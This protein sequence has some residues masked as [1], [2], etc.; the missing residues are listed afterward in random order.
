MPTNVMRCPVCGYINTGDIY[1]HHCPICKSPVELFKPD[2]GMEERG[3]WDTKSILMIMEMAKTGHYALEGKG[4]TRSF[5]N[6]DDLVFLPA[7]IDHMPLLESEPVN[8]KVILG[9]KAKQP[10]IAHTPILNAGMSF[11]ALSRE[12][13]LALAK[14][15]AIVG[16]VANS[17]EGGMLDEERQSSDNYTLQYSTGRFGISDDRLKMAD[18]IEIKISQGAK[19]GMGGKLPGIK[20]TD[21]IALIRYKI[22]V[23]SNS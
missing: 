5:L 15:S 7:Q 13:K 6:L 22:C 9:K 10:V 1:S 23:F 19:P 2:T 20:V 14:G 8:G 3:N 21:E 12:A 16:G 11:G 17:G 18:M 4:T